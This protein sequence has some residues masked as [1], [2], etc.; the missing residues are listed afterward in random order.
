MKSADRAASNG[1][2]AKRKDFPR[3]HR[4]IAI[5]KFRQR[6]HQYV[7]PHQKYSRRQRKNRTGF[8]ERAQ[9]IPRREQQPHR[10]RRRGKS[11][12]DQRKRQRHAAER[13]RVRPRRRFRHPLPGHHHEQ[14]QRHTHYRRF[15]HAAGPHKS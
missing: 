5:D 8:N 4:S 14:H 1:N 11:I 9:I 10:Q 3:E 2:K 13:K 7:R 15:H 6:R 12:G